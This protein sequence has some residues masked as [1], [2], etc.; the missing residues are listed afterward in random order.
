MANQETPDWL[1]RLEQA[2]YRWDDCPPPA[3]EEEIAALARCVGRPLPGDYVAFL[4]R[5]DGGA[6]W[7]RDVW[8]L[9]LWRAADIPEWSAAYGFGPQCIPGAVAIGSDGGGEG[10]VLDARPER[11]D[12]IYPIYAVNF[13]SIRWDEALPI[14]PDF[15]SLLLLRRELLASG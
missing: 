6:L 15:R 13:V 9:R 10:I 14:A 7:Y 2:D 12:G 11:V 5:H 4:Q 3:T 1:D 8:Y